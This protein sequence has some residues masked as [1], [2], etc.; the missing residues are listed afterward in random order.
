LRCRHKF[1]KCHSAYHGL[2]GDKFDNGGITRLD[3][4]GGGFNR[5]TRSAIDLLN[6]LRELAGDVGGVAIENGS[7]SSTNLTRVVEDDDLGVEGSGLLGG[8][9]LGVGGNVSTA[10]V[11]DRHV[12]IYNDQKRI[13]LKN[14]ENRLLDVEADVVSGVALL[15]LLV[16]HFDGL[17]FS[18]DV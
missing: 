5:F 9:V 14:R 12:P 4:L 16:V 17:D 11:L 15:K 1:Y 8:I 2:A 10:D 3:E 6:E 18:G 7:V 13:K